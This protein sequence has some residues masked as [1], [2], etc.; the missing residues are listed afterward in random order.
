MT[1]IDATMKDA[2]NATSTIVMPGSGS[3]GM[4][5]VARQWATNK[6]V[7]VLRNG[8]FSYRWTDIFDQTAGAS[9]H[10]FMRSRIRSFA[11]DCLIL[12]YPVLE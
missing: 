4:E 12:E 7:M 8:Y 5:S 10:A 11:R 9:N 6:K 1:D 2:Y 3:Y